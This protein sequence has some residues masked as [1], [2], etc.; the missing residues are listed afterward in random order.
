M[1]KT[2]TLKSKKKSEMITQFILGLIMIVFAA[3]V[4]YPFLYCVAYS[5]SDSVAVS[6]RNVTLLPIGLTFENYVN[7][8]KKNNILRPFMVSVGRTCGGV[9]WTLFVT[10]LASYAISK[11]RMP[12]NRLITFL[13][14]IPM[15]VS[16]GLIPTYV[17]MFKIHLYNN[18]LIYI[19][20]KGFFAFNMLLMRTYFDTLPPEL[21]E[22]ARLDGAS[23]LVIFARIVLPISMPI[24][25]VIANL[26]KMMIIFRFSAIACLKAGMKAT[27]GKS[28]SASSKLSTSWRTSCINLFP[29]RFSPPRWTALRLRARHG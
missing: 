8:F 20:P 27:P 21:E 10:G 23:D 9:A 15:Y 16:G 3:L 14:I 11:R 19:L 7:V 2:E 25:A 12:F 22:S 4:M 28:R 6:T 24:V 1:Q 5:L 18:F 26:Y 17:L 29:E 13:L